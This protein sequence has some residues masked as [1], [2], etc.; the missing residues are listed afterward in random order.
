MT[1]VEVFRLMKQEEDF[2]LN[3]DHS[4]I[5]PK[6]VKYVD[7]RYFLYPGGG[8]MHLFEES[9]ETVRKMSES[10]IIDDIKKGILDVVKS[11]L[12]CMDFKGID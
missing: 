7:K 8:G 2:K 4:L 9:C 5:K 3:Y 6:I 1:R 10:A 11:K 12:K